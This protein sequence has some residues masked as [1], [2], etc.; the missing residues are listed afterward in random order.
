MVGAGFYLLTHIDDEPLPVS[1][2]VN[3]AEYLVT[4]GSLQFEPLGEHDALLGVD[5]ALNWEMSGRRI[6]Q[7]AADRI[8]SSRQTFRRVS[9]NV[10][11]FPFNPS[12]STP[13]YT[14]RLSGDALTLRAETKHDRPYSPARLFGRDRTWHFQAAHE[15]DPGPRFRIEG[16][17]WHVY[18]VQF[19][20]RSVR[21][22]TRVANWLFGR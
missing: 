10:V 6:T 15:Q 3:G 8:I 7:S 9:E 17:S 12:G 20:G 1:L 16:Q 21:W 11:E 19:R 18:D 14:V 4:A 13:E 2:P 22:L 5:G